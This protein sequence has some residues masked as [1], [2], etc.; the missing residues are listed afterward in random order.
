[1]LDYVNQLLLAGVLV[2]YIMYRAIKVKILKFD[3]R[4]LFLAQAFIIISF[5]DL[6]TDRLMCLESVPLIIFSYIWGKIVPNRKL[7][8]IIIGIVLSLYGLFGNNFIN[9]SNHMLYFI[10]IYAGAMAC[11][12]KTTKSKIV[13]CICICLGAIL[14]LFNMSNLKESGILKWVLAQW[15]GWNS[16]KNYPWRF[17]PN[18]YGDYSTHCMWMDY[19]RDYGLVVMVLLLVFLVLSIK[20]VIILAIEKRIPFDE[21][22]LWITSFVGFNIYYL[23][24]ADAFEYNVRYLWAFGLVFSGIIRSLVENMDYKEAI[25]KI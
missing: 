7:T 5:L 13:T 19:G 18:I 3:V 16:L 2:I 6:K 15:D 12:Y 8:T 4:I 10:V 17:N 20:D 1:M 23:F 22:V 25:K 21:K 9:K 24:E 14:Q 11:V